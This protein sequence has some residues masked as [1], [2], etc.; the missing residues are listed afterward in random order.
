MPTRSFIVSRPVPLR[1]ARLG[2]GGGKNGIKQLIK[3]LL[4]L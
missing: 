2:S 4:N 1:G 3:S